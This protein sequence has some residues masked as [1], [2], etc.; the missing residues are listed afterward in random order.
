M[1][2]YFIAN[3]KLND[4]SWIP[5][6]AANVHDIVHRHGGKY[7][8]RS[9]NV[10][11]LEGPES[12]SNLVAVI[13]FPSQG[14]AQAFVSDPDYAPYADARKAGTDSQIIGIDATDAAGTIAYLTPGG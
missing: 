6:Y 2:Y 7:L 1:A 10:T 11:T 4:D 9:A 3:V 5:E 12:T 8:S 13:E 14:D